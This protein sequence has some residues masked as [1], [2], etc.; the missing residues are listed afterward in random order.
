MEFEQAMKFIDEKIKSSDLVVFMKGTSEFPMCGFSGRVVQILNH[1]GK[2]FEGINVLEDDNL[3]SA[4][5]E[6]SKWP[7]IPQVYLK[8]EFIGGCDI[9]TE[10]AQTGE[11]EKVFKEK[12][13]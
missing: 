3:R 10:M 7:T 5:K 1:F 9:L 13:G 8:G 4:I 12:L 2:N 6:Y 11:L